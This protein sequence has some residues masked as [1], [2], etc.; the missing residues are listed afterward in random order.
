MS[1]E[2]HMKYMNE[3]S[4][5]IVKFPQPIVVWECMS[6]IGVRKDLRLEKNFSRRTGYLFLI[7]LQLDQMQILWE[8][9]WESSEGD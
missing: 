9:S 5:K 8:I 4:E 3:M 6:T 2:I 1:G 7:G